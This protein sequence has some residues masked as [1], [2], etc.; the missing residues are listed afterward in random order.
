MACDRRSKTVFPVC[1]SWAKDIF[2]QVDFP[3]LASFPHSHDARCC[4]LQ[5]TPAV[6]V[7]GRADKEICVCL[8]QID[9]QGTP[10]ARYTAV[11]K[12]KEKE[13]TDQKTMMWSY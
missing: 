2:F 11:F 8:P 1:V 3:A 4:S 13:S 12:K 9:W 10:G 5:D 6:R 7:T